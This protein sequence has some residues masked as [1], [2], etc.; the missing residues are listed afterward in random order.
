MQ[1]FVIDA[2]TFCRLEEQRSGSLPIADLPRVAV[3]S[4]GAEGAGLTWS[5]SGGKD[6]LDHAKLVLA[7]NGSV[8]LMCQRCLTP[9]AL[10]IDSESILILAKNEASADEIDALLDDDEV[11]VVVGSKSFDVIALIEDEVLLAIPQSPKHAVCPDV[12]LAF[13][14]STAGLDAEGGKKASPFAVLKKIN[15]RT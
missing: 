7:V 14:N 12:S 10:E 15:G 9:F 4:V 3:E 2:F 13:A 8:Q 1:A 5:L 11:D 6:K